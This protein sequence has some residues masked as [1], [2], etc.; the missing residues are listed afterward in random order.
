[1]QKAVL[2]VVAVCAAC[3][4]V[5]ALDS[6]D[7][8]FIKDYAMLKIYESC[9]GTALLKQIATELK[10]AY[11]KCSIAPPMR[12]QTNQQATGGMP[13]LLSKLPPGFAMDPNSQTITKPSDGANNYNQENDLPNQDEPQQHQKVP[14]YVSR[15][16]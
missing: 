8:K 7:N 16:R 15:K 3:T 6:G 14:N 12:E 4:A 9:F 1:M 13:I 2:L 11:T 10:E 5:H